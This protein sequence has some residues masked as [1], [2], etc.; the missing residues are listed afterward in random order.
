MPVKGF[1]NLTLDEFTLL[2]VT[3][4]ELIVLL[5]YTLSYFRGGFQKVNMN[6]LS[7]ST[8]GTVWSDF[9]G[10]VWAVFPEGY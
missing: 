9:G 4:L 2:P 10:P 3:G 1:N 5:L 6:F 8:A 7:S